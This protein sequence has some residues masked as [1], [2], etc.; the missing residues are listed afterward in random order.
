MWKNTNNTKNKQNA[1]KRRDSI[2]ML[3][4]ELNQAKQDKLLDNMS[5]SFFKRLQQRINKR[6]KT[7][8]ESIL[9]KSTTFFSSNFRRAYLQYKQTLPYRNVGI[10]SYKMQDLNPRFQKEFKTRIQASLNLI[11]TQNEENMLRLKR[12]LIDWVTMSDFRDKQDLKEAIALPKNKRI[13]FI[14]RD[15]ENKLCGAMDDIVAENYNAI[16]F[17]WKT[18]ND[19]RVVGKPS[20]LYPK[21]NDNSKMHGDHWSRRGKFYYYPNIDQSIKNKLNL[22]NFAGSTKDLK[23]G[24]PGQPIG[25]RCWAKNYYDL[26]DLPDELL[27]QN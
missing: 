8:F 20:G 23:D 27:K 18:R 21:A 3:I 7:K 17:E 2:Q 6:L 16:C 9:N 12:R 4:D 11:K 15:Q 19:N 22:K 10:K 24:M 1:Q 25:C 5:P 14:L 13:K 26:E